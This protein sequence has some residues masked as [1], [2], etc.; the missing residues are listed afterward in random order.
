M[1]RLLSI[2]LC[3]VFGVVYAQA[4]M[5]IQNDG[6]NDYVLVPSNSNVEVNL[7]EKAYDY[8]IKVY[9][10]AGPNSSYGANCNG[11]IVFIAPP[12][13]K[14]AVTGSINTESGWDY[15]YVYDGD[16]SGTQLTSTSG[17]QSLDYASSDRQLTIKFTSDGSVFNPGFDL[18]VTVVEVEYPNDGYFAYDD[19]EM[20]ILRGYIGTG[21]TAAIPSSVV[22]I[23]A[24]AFKYNSTLTALDFSAAD[25][26]T[27][28]GNKAFY[29]CS[30][31]TEIALPDN[32]SSI[33]TDAFA[34]G[35]KNLVY[36]GS[37]GSA[38]DK[39]GATVRNGTIDNGFVFSD[40]EKTNLMAYGG[41]DASIE[42]PATVTQIANNA[43]R[44]NDALT[45]V[46]FSKATVL[47]TI[48]S[49]A[50]YGCANL[51]E[52]SL[53]NN[54][55]TIGSDAFANGVKNL[56]YNGGAGSETDT[57]G[58]MVR[59]G[60]LD[61]DFVYGNQAK[62]NLKKYTG[63]DA[64]VEIPAT[65]IEIASHAF[66]NN[67]NLTAVDFSK[68]TGLTTIG[69]YAFY[70]CSNLATADFSNATALTTI[71]N[72]AFY[73]CDK[74]ASVAIPA[75]VETIGDYA[76]EYCDNLESIDFSNATA[77]TNIGNYAFRDCPKIETIDLSDATSLKNIYS[78]AFYSCNKLAEVTL[79]DG[80][81]YIG[82]DVFRYCSK[83]TEISVPASVTSIGSDAFAD[84]VMNLL[85]D[86]NAGSE[87]DTW[88]AQMRNGVIDGDFIYGNQAKTILAKYTGSSASVE[89]PATVTE[90]A[91]DAFRNNDV[92]TAVDFSKATG[93]TTIG[94]YAFYD[95][96][97]LTTV[98]IPAT[99]E[100]IGS[101][102]FYSCNDLATVDFSNADALT[103][104]G[105]YAFYDCD[106]IT[107]VTIPATV[108]TIG[109][110]AFYDCS[111]LA[112]VDF[113]N[114]DALTTIGS[115]S[116]YNC[117]KITSVTIPAAVETIGQDAFYSCSN[118]ASVDFSNAAALTTIGYQTFFDC[119]KIET[120]DLSDATAFKTI[121]TQAFYSCDNLAEVT[122]PDG[123]ET[124]NGE[125]F[126]YCGKLV[127][128][129][130]PASVTSIGSS[131]FANG[132][133][134]LLYN[135]SAGS[136]TDKWGALARNGIIDGDFIYGDQAKTILVKYS[137]SDASV[138]IPAQVTEI[139]SNAFYNNDNLTAVDFSK[140]TGLTTIGGYAFLDCD[141]I[142]EITIPATVETI[143]YQAFNSCDKLATVDLSNAAA[144]TAIGEYAF[145]ECAELTAIAIPATVE[146]I[147][148]YAFYNC[149]KLATVD[150][151]N[152]TA[153]RTIGQY[154]FYDCNKLT[155]VDL[156]GATN[157]TTIY[158]QAFYGCNA[159]TA[160]VIPSAVE[161]IG[162]SAF[163]NCYKLA[164]VDFSN[165]AS[166]TS[167]GQEAF[168]Y[169][170]S[171]TAV[172]LNI[173]T[174]LTTINNNAFQGCTNLTLIEFIG[175]TALTTIGQYAFDNSGDLVC[176][177]TVPDNVTSIGSSAFTG[178]KNIEYN[179]SAGNASSTWGALT[180]N[181]Y[182]DGNF[183]YADE[184]HKNLTGYLA[185]QGA[186][187]IPADVETIGDNAFDRCR[188]LSITIPA[189]N[190]LTTISSTAFNG[191]ALVINNSD[192]T[193]N[194]P[195][196]ALNVNATTDSDGFVYSDEEKTQ[197]TGYIGSA[198]SVVI[199][200]SVT[201]IGGYAFRGSN[202]TAIDLSEATGLSSIGDY[203][204]YDCAN[205]TA[206]T[207]PATVT[208]VGT[209]A[210]VNCNNLSI[211]FEGSS[212][213]V[214]L[215]NN[216]NSSNRPV[217]WMCN[218]WDLENGVLTV[219][220]DINFGNSSNYPW[221]NQRSQVTSVEFTSNVTLVGSYAFYDY[222]NLSSV[223][224]SQATGLTQINT[225]A[226]YSCDNLAAVA[227]PATVETIG[228]DAFQ[229][230]YAM[231][232][233]DLSQA[234]AL[235]NINSYA[236]QNCDKITRVIIPETVTYFGS[237]AFDNCD[238]L[239]AV[240][241]EAE[242]SNGISL[243]Y[244]WNG[245][246]P[247]GW[248]YGNWELS[249][250][251]VLTVKK[252]YSLN[253][254]DYYKWY[255]IRSL[256]K[257]VEFTSDVTTIGSYAFYDYD[258]MIEAEIPSTI[259][260]IGS[261]AF[262]SC[263][264]LETVDFSNATS[265]NSI[266]YRAFYDDQKLTDADLGN[267]TSLLSIGE[268]AFYNC[269]G[270]ASTDV[271]DG[272]ATIGSNAF[273]RIMNIN[274]HGYAGS[275]TDTWGALCRNGITDG[276]FLYQDEAKTIIAG[277]IGNGGNVTIPANVVTIGNYAFY[278]CDSVK[279]VTLPASLTKI[280]EYAFAD[281]D[282]LTAVTIP[283]AVSEIGSYA[284]QSCDRLASADL[285]NATSLNYINNG[286]FE[287]CHAL[288]NLSLPEQ[289]TSIN[290]SAFYNCD[291]LTTVTI[292]AAVTSIGDN[293][294]YECQKLATVDFSQATGLTYIGTYAFYNCDS[295]KAITIPENVTTIYNDAFS[296]CD[297]L[298]TVDL[299]QA[300][301]LTTISSYAFQYSKNL[302]AI[303]IPEKVTSIG[304]RAFGD[305][306]K[307]ATV[308]M[309]Q[310]ASLT[311]IGDYAFYNC[312]SL[313]TITIP[314]KVNS[315]GQYMLQSCDSLSTIDFSQATSLT[316]I[317]DRAF[318]DCDGL[319]SVTI[320]ANV[321]SISD[322]AFY[323]CNKLES[324]NCSEGSKL[325]YISSYAFN[326][327]YKLKSVDLSNATSLTTIGDNAF[328]NCTELETVLIPESIVRVNT[329]SFN[330]CPNLQYTE[331]GGFKYLGN[332][333]NNYVVLMEATSN[334]VS[335]STVNS[336][337]KAVRLGALSNCTNYVTE[338]NGAYYLGNDD[339]AYVVLAKASS[340]SITE[341]E[342]N[343]DTKVIAPYAFQN[344]S[345]LATVS[346]PETVTGIGYYAFNNTN[347]SLVIN[348]PATSRLAGWDESWNPNGRKVNWG[349]GKWSVDEN[350]TLTI[351]DCFALTDYSAY[352]WYEKRSQ[353]KKV[354]F[355]EGV[356]CVG[357][358]AFFNE[359]NNYYPNLTEVVLPSTIESIGEQAFYNCYN[360]E[361]FEFSSLTNLAYIGNSA[362]YNCDKLTAAD[363][364]NSSLTTI[365]NY[366]FYNC[367]NLAEVKFP[368]TLESIGSEAF[369][370]CDKIETADLSN[371]SVSSIAYR[372]FYDCDGLTEVKFPAT[373]ESIGDQAFNSCNYIA[374]ADFSNCTNLKSI[375]SQAFYYNQ[376][377]ANADFSNLTSLETL[378]SEAFRDCDKLEVVDLSN[379]KLTSIG[380]YA[381]RYCDGLT[382][383][384]FPATLET[385]NSHAF[386]SCSN[387]AEIDL[388]AQTPNLKTIGDYAFSGVYNATKVTIPE[389]IETIGYQA[390]YANYTICNKL[391]GIGYV[392]NS[393]N[394]YL[395]LVE[396]GEEKDSYTISN[397]TRFI[398]AYAFSELSSMLVSIDVPETVTSIS[399]D[400]F[401]NVMNVNY[402]GPAGDE[403]STWGALVR[404][405]C[406]DGAFVYADLAKTNLVKY[407]GYNA[408][409]V[410]PATVTV[411]SNYAFQDK[412]LT[413]VDF[414]QATGLK[415]IGE[416]AFYNCDGLTEVA[417]PASVEAISQY[418]FYDCNNLTTVDLSNASS[419]ASIGYQAFFSC[420]KL[421]NLDLENATSIAS[422]GN[423]AFKY[424]Y[425]LT[426]IVIPESVAT[427]GNYAFS[428]CSKLES[429]DF[430]NATALKT[431]GEYAFYQSKIA[432]VDLSGAT[433]LTSI[434][435][436]AFYDCDN[437]TTAIIDN[438]GATLKTIGS[439]AFDACDHLVCSIDVPAS[440]TSIGDY[441]FRYVKNINYTGTAGN[442]TYKW[443]AQTRNGYVDGDFVYADA[444]H[445][446][447]TG[448]LAA[449]GEVEIPS[450]V[451]S[452]GSLAFYRCNNVSA[453]IPESVTSIASDAF[454][455][456]ANVINNSAYTT[457]APWGARTYNGT[458]DEDGFIY[459]DAE[460][461]NL[462]G[463]CGSATDIVIPATVT[464]IGD[465]AFQNSALTSVDLSEA[466]GLTSIGQYVFE[467]S[468]NLTSITIPATVTWVGY[469]AF[470]GCDNLS[471]NCEK[472]SS[473]IS[474]NSSWNPSNR[475]VKWMCNAWDLEDGVLTVKQDVSFN[476]SSYYP[477][478]N[479][480]GQVTS[481]VLTD[482][483]TTVGNFAFYYCE[484]LEAVTIPASVET[485]GDQAFYNCYA[486]ANLDL[487][488]ATS[489]TTIGYEAFYNCDQIR[490]VTIP[491]SVTTVGY[492]I[493]NYCD[494]IQIIFCEAESRP[495]NW[496][497]SWNYTYN[498]WNYIT[499]G[500]DYA[501][502][503]IDEDGLMTVK[504][505]Y[506]Y[507]SRD[508][509]KW[510]PARD[511][512]RGVEF[513][514]DVTAIGRYA[515]SSGYY[516]L[517]SITIPA[518][519][520]SVGL[521]AFLDCYNVSNLDLS[522]ATGLTT[523]G[524]NA[525]YDMPGIMS[526][527]IPD[528]VSTIGNNAFY[529]IK[530][531]NYYGN[532]G[533]ATEKWGALS[534]NGYVEDDFIFADDAMTHLVGYVGDGGSIVI[535]ATTVTIG[536][537]AFS[538][539]TGI[540]SV[541]IP[542]SVVTIGNNAFNGCSSLETLD[543]SKATSLTTIGSSAFSGANLGAVTIPATVTSLGS[544]AFAYNN[545]LASADL[546]KATGLTYINTGMF[547]SCYSLTNVKVPATI[548][549]IGESAF[550]GCQSLPNAVIPENV[551]YI[552]NYAFNDCDALTS[553]TIPAKVS[554]IGYNAFA[555]CDNLATVDMS[556]ATGLTTISSSL[557]QYCT[558]LT[559]VKLPAKITSIESSAFSQCT[560][561]PKITIP[562][563]VTSIGSY[564]FNDCESLTNVNIP[565]GV[566]QISDNTF[567]YCYSLPSI[568]IPA[569][570]T[571]IGS[572]AFYSC[573]ALTS[574]AIPSKVTSIGSSAFSYCD[575]LAT[576]DFSNATSLTTIN[577]NA[578]EYNPKLTAV[579][580][581][582]ATS[583]TTINSYAFQDCDALTTVSIPEKVTS[584]PYR[585]FFDCDALETVDLSK[586]TSI[587]AIGS[588]AFYSCNKLKSVDMSNTS[589]VNIND[590]AFAYCSA[591]ESV[592]IP[593]SVARVF[594]NAFYDCN[595]LQYTEEDGFKYLGNDDNNYVVLMAA[596]NSNVSAAKVNSNVKTVAN[597]SGTIGWSN[598]A[599]E[600]N[601][602]YYVG[603]DEN[604]H[605]IL[606][607]ATS[608]S[609]SSCTINEN[610][611][612]I[613][614]WAFYNCYNLTAIEI[615]ESVKNIG[616]YAFSNTNGSLAITTYESSRPASWDDSWNPNGRKVN[617]GKDKW[618][619]DNGVLTI[620]DC[621]DMTSTSAYPWYAQRNSITKV[622]FEEGVSCIGQYAFSGNSYPYLTE[623]VVP[624]TL[625]TIA[626][627][628][629]ENCYSLKNLDLSNATNLTTIGYHAFYGCNKWEDA[630]FS[631]LT[632]LA[633]I[634]SE[635]FRNC[636]KITV[637]DLSNTVVTSLGNYS[638]YDCDAL[639][640]VDF[641]A[642]LESIGQ[643]A[644]NSCNYLVTADFSNCTNLK[645]IGY[646]AFR[647]N[648]RLVNADFSNLTSLET[649]DN[650][651]FYYCYNLATVDL[652]NTK[653]TTIGNNEFYNCDALTSVVL[654]ATLKTINGYAFY[655]CDNLTEVAIPAAVESIGNYAF[656]S[657][658]QLE[659]VDMSNAK[660]LK[661]I[662]EGAFAD[663]YA[664]SEIT[665]PATVETIG[666]YAFNN[667]SNLQYTEQNGLGYL[668]NSKNQY[669]YLGKVM[670]EQES[671][672]INSKT[673]F[674]GSYT[675]QNCP[676]SSIDVPKTVTEIAENAFYGLLNINYN[677]PAGTATSTWGAM[678][679]NAVF[680]KEFIYADAQ[681]TIIVKYIG[682]G[683][684]VVIPATV[685]EIRSEAF[686]NCQ[687]LTSVDFSQATGLTYIGS[688]A[689]YNCQNLTSA[690]FSQ[691]SA[692]T[693]IGSYAF[694]NTKL[695]EVTIPAAVTEIG[696]YAFQ[697]CQA[698]TTVD[699]SQNTG[700]TSLS[701]V[702]YNCTHLANFSW[703]VNVA[704][705]DSYTFYNCDSLKVVNIP[706]SVKTIYSYAFEGCD[707]IKVITLRRYVERVDY[708][709]LTYNRKATIYCEAPSRPGNW[710]SN[711]NYNYYNYLPVVWGCKVIEGMPSYEGTVEIDGENYAFR[712]VEGALW[713]LPDATDATATITAVPAEY[714][715]F[716]KWRNSESTENPLTIDVTESARFAAL[717][718]GDDCTID[719][720]AENGTVTGA[721]VYPYKSQ[722]TLEAIADEHYHFVGWEDGVET[723]TRKVRVKGD[724]VL[725][726]LFELDE[727]LISATVDNN[728]TVA[729]AGKTYKWGSNATLTVRPAT[730]YHFVNWL[731]DP[732]A[733]A[734]RTVQVLGDAS[735]AAHTEINVYAVTVE[736]ENGTVT[737]TPEGGVASAA[738][739]SGKLGDFA[740]GTN[741][742]FEAT[743]AAGYKFARWNKSSTT[744]PYVVAVSSDLALTPEFILASESVYTIA[745]TATEGGRVTGGGS[746]LKNETATLSAVAD[747][748][749]HFVKWN[750][751]STDETLKVK[752]SEN[753]NYKAEFAIN[754]YIVKVLAADNNGTVTGAGT[755]TFDTEI[756]LAATANTGYKFT[757]W[758]DGNTQNPRT[759]KV[760][761]D[762]ELTAQFD[763]LTFKVIAKAD[764]GGTVTGSGTYNYGA[765]AK[766][767]AIPAEGYHFVEWS[768]G[769]T[770]NPRTISN[771]TENITL[772]A[773]FSN[774]VECTV[775][776]NGQ[777]G[778]VEGT[779]VYFAGETAT[780]KAV[781][782][783]GYKF[784]CWSDGVTAN[785]RRVKVASDTTLTAQ[786]IDANLGI[787]TVEASANNG[788]VS[789]KT[790]TVIEGTSVTLTV[791]PDE[792]FKFLR[793]SN[794]SNNATL[795]FTV[796]EDVNLTA[797]CTDKEICTVSATGEN[798]TF[799]GTGIFAAGETTTI[800]AVGNEGF[801]FLRWT[802]GSMENP[803][804]VRVNGNVTLTAQFTAESNGIFTIEAEGQNGTVEGTGIFAAG[805]SVTLTPVADEGYKFARWSDGSYTAVRTFT[806][807]DNVSLTAKFIAADKGIFTVSASG[808]N[809]TVTGTGTFIQGESTTLNPVANEG[810][811][812][813]R[814]SD[815]LYDAQRKLVVASDTTFTAEFINESLGIYTVSA[816]AK[817]GK[818]SGTG[819]F[820]EGEKTTLV[821]VAKSGYRF[822]R[823]SD[824]ITDSVRTITVTENVKLKAVFT[825]AENELFTVK[826][827][828]VNGVVEGTGTFAVGDDIVLSA[829]ANE[830]Y[831]FLRWSDGN[832]DSVRTVTVSADLLGLGVEFTKATNGIYRL[833]VSA[834][835]DGT[836]TGTGVYASDEK[837]TVTATANEGY[838]FAGWSD[839]N[840]DNPRVIT[841]K[842]DMSITAEFKAK[843]QVD[844]HVAIDETEATDVVIYA[845]GNT[846]VVENATAD[847]YLFDAMGRLVDHVAANA[848]RTEIL[849]NGQG[850]YVVKTGNA[851]QRVMIQ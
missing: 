132:V 584:I 652:S 163:K 38:T 522:D 297:K 766:L 580:L 681:K 721:G 613:A 78:Q 555:Y 33:G 436:Y 82:V 706:S 303:V 343:E 740:H 420:N 665:I 220:E 289:I 279:S 677:G 427:I 366:T 191:V 9:D 636:D 594:S 840:T 601:G 412:G 126:C 644:F 443:G 720:V 243:N 139:A 583:L 605:L 776:A 276:D 5:E 638:F 739:A 309:S 425:S 661:K 66:V 671:Y 731:D 310:A 170:N 398:G 380:S 447:L 539:C 851:V 527:D 621:F 833:Y 196:G 777:N 646:Q 793:W 30:N 754:A 619:V 54:V 845:Y 302:E 227:I 286:L 92:L 790:G 571:Y 574:V 141:N 245:G 779:G 803:R 69:D 802:D 101:Y 405:G 742:T 568:T 484:H 137:G 350:G 332:D 201:S 675:F 37:A 284:F 142:T 237:Y 471:I 100:T 755:Y 582:K 10:H 174:S 807:S 541:S 125:A 784:F 255:G 429:V 693:T 17:Y 185:T 441:A 95:C 321:T 600:E 80:L 688:N 167:I 256:I 34:N 79:P 333:Q 818:V 667:C 385:I 836:A 102:A 415:N 224:F 306:Q 421:A 536:E 325:K 348:T 339:N 480:R 459:A 828:A 190:A 660:N 453:T 6:V 292:P 650:E 609:I 585:G 213:S 794:G 783:E 164:T 181:G 285:S 438:G 727:H 203:A 370:D 287:N 384:K 702:F 345:S 510:Y 212:S 57:W 749:Y 499:T 700:L 618:E 630:D 489:L 530:N 319:K 347:S 679:R 673:K 558:S 22:T 360:V 252:D 410:I 226:F 331:E 597:F 328:A 811:K 445:K 357:Y 682:N 70:N 545:D 434:G 725:T 753:A 634:G 51:A 626:D 45:A 127:E 358:R 514:S 769:V 654:P 354:V 452:I 561:L 270:I 253:S 548:T 809:G 674:V 824:G 8:T 313:R 74:I 556:K 178:I 401:S 735:Y 813:A 146:T 329:Y 111:N 93:L 525:F 589:L 695:T 396:A 535:P 353:I 67:N 29:G 156:S 315:L 694:Y 52:I 365:G 816:S 787:F 254:N 300:A 437:L 552:G 515:F 46:D 275:E 417:I 278:N 736:T 648:E 577:S 166:L 620:K 249:A 246:K 356:S 562:E 678:A 547:E 128:L 247:T 87:T 549:S 825:N 741:V 334:D 795:T 176:S 604:P 327:G 4:Q 56:I 75:T 599:T 611:E 511:F 282:Y 239:Q 531:I 60:V 762:L 765:T 573:D 440:V 305:C 812:F 144:L 450:G 687:A 32:V 244:Y 35:V 154:A 188:N 733:T 232:D 236:F 283:A 84:G 215:A 505:N 827:N 551:T 575:N 355:E 36:N 513:T 781:G 457:N 344:C 269:Y 153:L 204:F 503:S 221:Y 238:K 267:A 26:L 346:I 41:S 291:S 219:K 351:T 485:I 18:N 707:S 752:V 629:F 806:V 726:A 460:K 704:T 229:N 202:I 404:N 698:L 538:N 316:T 502:W 113:S 432:E 298:A 268:G 23:K 106:K 361:G 143:G 472:A 819:T 563:T 469:Y 623:V 250:D 13:A 815:G 554:Q 118:L 433:A 11:S 461:T 557:F 248:D 234:T 14:L 797:T 31:L 148:Q 304:Y 603:N 686:S 379:S 362:F 759:L 172:N 180:R 792:G 532:A 444:D 760:S 651:A 242:S 116:F 281:C 508:S 133:K 428:N 494:N 381:F 376:N 757:K 293:A 217:K 498:S 397:K 205:L 758:S 159:L 756:T 847:I 50:F 767:E 640:E 40:Q 108:E 15:V 610:T 105:S 714:Y 509:Y 76:F 296:Y 481:V 487:S 61:G 43:F 81:E 394:P 408:Q 349:V 564:A 676:V 259:E 411:I 42:I 83:L 88:G 63:S 680:D 173:S 124:I 299:S 168:R 197:L 837:I 774:K 308:D 337:V 475:P 225:Y 136:A 97:K 662:S 846:V 639:T 835:S 135:G 89:I 593:E 703:P 507:N 734:T 578:F 47:T 288:A 586:A 751:G 772:T 48:G 804:R 524:Q 162:N 730:G 374:T 817:N 240:L 830:G 368:A 338:E 645:S 55:T 801:K 607:K 160:V 715:H 744:N 330:N 800:N 550:S 653:L 110:Y 123:L 829:I 263:N 222:N 843:P 218:A 209:F 131:A 664:L 341:C 16:L 387:L 140:A 663:C 371:T 670:T 729:G 228:S 435:N 413:S 210:F 672:T 528:Q 264:K 280:G 479:Q 587:T 312:D 701:Y 849:V 335:A 294:F 805:E 422:I 745:A 320:P 72:Y 195:W 109:Q 193:S 697:N 705:I 326:A 112:T 722:A 211:E 406:V 378:G 340:T 375:G 572:G 624:S 540:T 324:V 96:D 796:S 789:G 643:N 364:S 533:T 606:V 383:V 713:Y 565:S 241:C 62:T 391:D 73:N 622:V 488:Q 518:T 588:Q 483:V 617:W 12:S 25:N 395:Y 612:I 546:S 98:T 272:V 737:A 656:A 699:M 290:Y 495:S 86:G 615:P 501:N 274:Y 317:R 458:V 732:Q 449:S 465:K 446:N 59:N 627:Y 121:S 235:K 386:N 463:Y 658:N 152:A 53:P 149:D 669:L 122:L 493:F 570:V 506:D 477:W 486:M 382:E 842:S 277:Y 834:G 764:K 271:P 71:G 49:N 799:T 393:T 165:A 107:S 129:T 474:W 723:A 768:D 773:T 373:L 183:V 791:V 692:L 517:N 523:I 369:R 534:R 265:L 711:W 526:I 223:D 655:D 451:E 542:A 208:Y 7:T 566:T 186:V 352:P 307:L 748:G 470:N 684:D 231:A 712:D 738:L 21:A 200:S 691:C 657:C 647:Y 537:G 625:E 581:S 591:L 743:P 763:I 27:T 161:T 323:E 567:Q 826:V 782:N 633:T 257:S 456:V 500:W 786:F 336:N 448:Y 810:F 478:Y 207:I 628:A 192:Y 138:E 683:G 99:V 689:F 403:T 145:R 367:N 491:A 230:C 318:Y 44:N 130:V 206:I 199:P 258:N 151:S 637:A 103:T 685:K 198:T 64:S 848:D 295:L 158:E 821:P 832:R 409:I 377:L 785:P 134:N 155:T 521:N 314:A 39:W 820:I 822:V 399:N 189:D 91:T 262:Y 710:N 117:Y 19:E 68:A 120:I 746:Y 169:C 559:N 468:K 608:T 823:W 690:D 504:K 104:I 798:G 442:E 553:V 462:K 400:A 844:P 473:Q 668:G 157:L 814:W 560:S 392:G 214:S 1:K 431:I 602:A 569:N 641:P 595:K 372:A 390:I 747:N 24:N 728:G 359:W 476:S 529:N 175:A 301:S 94:N 579:D 77:L 614:P 266:G 119:D 187:E 251:S 497:S 590:A 389:S 519:I 454:S 418:A 770:L 342:V 194:S 216:W 839:G 466:T 808:E 831:K 430:S 596:T 632:S 616:Y 179:G 841:L 482:N 388:E 90:I 322:Y 642:T 543:L 778:T 576:V 709:M 717:Y 496:N 28:I 771:I 718:E 666:N 850:I 416:G 233:L 708:G 520:T 455:G 512:I 58:A 490:R 696:N 761:E 147:G 492:R 544:Y 750:T 439:Y 788:T 464:Q 182:I 402:N 598:F 115:Y 719:V 311:T 20:T 414:S 631:N 635:A 171:L 2:L 780:L 65:V 260:S 467:N 424:C 114:A 592:S 423:E 85:Y 426:D 724:M 659:T 363:L 838:E 273:Y 516:N 419:L 150:L 716:V 177:I 3:L 261:Q 775:A 407:T 649:I 184:D